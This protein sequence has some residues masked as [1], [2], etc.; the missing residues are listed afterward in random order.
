MPRSPKLEQS[1]AING[2]AGHDHDH[3]ETNSYSVADSLVQ[4]ALNK[5][6]SGELPPMQA[7][8]AIRDIS[9]RFPEN[10]MANFTLGLM[11]MQTAQY[12]KA[13]DRFQKVLDQDEQYAD[14][15]LL[16]AR[17]RAAYGDTSQA[18]DGLN[19]ALEILSGE[20]IRNA[21]E[22]EMASINPN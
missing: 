1:E 15:H 4:D 7:V 12:E 5:M 22:T 16:L 14:A 6:Q 9:E 8:L 17:A 13:I 19:H 18:L 11:S 10:I 2:E 20:E 3:S 21:I